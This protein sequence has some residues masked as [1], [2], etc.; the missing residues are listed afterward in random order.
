MSNLPTVQQMYASFAQ[1][2]IPGVLATFSDNIILSNGQD[3]AVIPFGGTFNGK[4]GAIQF[5]T[6]L[7]ST[8]E[9]THFEPSN[10]HETG[11]TVTNHIRHD[12]IVRATGK[13]F[14]IRTDFAWTFNDQ[15]KASTWD[16]SGD[17]SSL[18]AAL[19]S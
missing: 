16:G 12:G 5:F 4:S 13:S 7:G 9:T 3:P 6:A 14:S 15:G 18:V 2:D 10:F 19:Q 1:G 17:Y 8:V 11:N